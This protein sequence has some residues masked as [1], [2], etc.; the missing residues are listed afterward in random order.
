MSDPKLDVEP[1][2][3]CVFWMTRNTTDGVLASTCEIWVARPERMR[4][5]DG[6]VM[7]M[8]SLSKI[9]EESAWYDE[10]TIAKCEKECR[11]TPDNDREVIVVGIPPAPD[12]RRG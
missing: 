11:V 4:F 3:N 1:R 5:D 8:G 10:W 7:W 6:D 9:D 2:P 12:T